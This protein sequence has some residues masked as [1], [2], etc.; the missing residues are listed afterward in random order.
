MSQVINKEGKP[1][2]ERSEDDKKYNMSHERYN[3][4]IDSTHNEH[5]FNQNVLFVY[6]VLIMTSPLVLG[7]QVTSFQKVPRIKKVLTIFILRTK[8]QEEKNIWQNKGVKTKTE[9]QNKQRWSESITH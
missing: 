6:I 8:Q 9:Y 2:N 1:I 4:I 7:W 5:C 3:W